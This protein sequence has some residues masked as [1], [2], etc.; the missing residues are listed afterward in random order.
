[1]K[2]IKII[3]AIAAVMLLTV[4]MP[5]AVFAD[6][7]GYTTDEFNVDITT[8]AD[9]VFHVSE[10]INVDFYEARHGIY[11]YIPE[12]GNLYAIKHVRVQGY[13][14]ETYTENSSLVIKIGSGDYYV[15]GRQT[16]RISYDI[17]GYKDSDDAKDMLA[18][19]LIPT[20]WGTEIENAK[21]TI[22]FPKKIDD[23]EVFSGRYKDAADEGYF[24]VSEDGKSLTAVSRD[25]VPQGVGLTIRADLP[26]G[27][28]ENP[29]D[30]STTL[31]G[32]YGILGALAALMLGLWG[33]VGRDKGVVKPVEFY[34]PDG[35]DPLQVDYIANDKIESKDVAA[36]F[37]YFANKG[38]LKVVG[39]E[40]KKFKVIKTAQIDKSE[41]SHAKAIFRALFAGRDEVDLKHLPDG[42]GEVLAGINSDVKDSFSKTPAF[43]GKSKAG[44]A[45]GTVICY[46]IPIL[47]G[48]FAAYYGFGGFWIMV[49]TVIT[50]LITGTL[51]HMLVRKADSFGGRKKPVKFVINAIVLICFILI[52][53]FIISR[54]VTLMA[55]VF[56]VTIVAAIIAT[57]FV[58]QRANNDIYGRVMGFK[59]FIKT[60]EYDRLKTLAEEDPEYYF[61]IM[62]YAFVFGMSNKWA[63]KFADFKI[64]Q[65]SWY[66]SDGGYYDIFFPRY[67]FMTSTSGISSTVGDYYKAIGADIAGDIGSSVGGGGGGFSGGGFG[68]GG[69]G[70]W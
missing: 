46:L 35:M 68:G 18:I 63:D 27:Y 22:T 19:D 48:G 12:G 30:R 32:A 1:M 47:A 70:S 3:A 41:K 17:V 9:H 45:V 65:P 40:K 55:L 34:P 43:T 23:I 16:Y 37:M 4:F 64:P 21:A 29:L 38:Y 51:A 61:N 42:L 28:W 52:H 56:I 50:G 36:M 53:A 24:L 60:A 26:E 44:R 54:Y 13:E 69:G 57:M 2:R 5:A 25:T 62:P 7:G 59:D 11:R 58:R 49:L 20:G 31:P 39:E 67:M 15:D 10:E 14:Y 8:D 66:E 6:S 33:A